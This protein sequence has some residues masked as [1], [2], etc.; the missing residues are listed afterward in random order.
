[1]HIVG[2]SGSLRKASYNSALLR[3]A[4]E[5]CPPGATLQVESIRGIPLYDGD[6]EDASGVPDFVDVAA[7]EID[8]RFLDTALATLGRVAEQP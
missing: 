6:E 8:R 5:E 7:E 3:A 4:V 2:I 1:M